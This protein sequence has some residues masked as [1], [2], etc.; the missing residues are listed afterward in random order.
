L[1]GIVFVNVHFHIYCIIIKSRNNTRVGNTGNTS[2]II[3]AK[4]P[5]LVRGRM[6]SYNGVTFN[7]GLT[8]SCVGTTM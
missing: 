5:G 2:C 6:R 7:I 4:I 8:C 1:R 3:V